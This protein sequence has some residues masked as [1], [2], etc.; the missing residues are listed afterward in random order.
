MFFSTFGLPKCILLDQ[1]SNFMSTMFSQVMR[2]LSVNHQISSAYHPE[3]QGVLERFLQTLKSMLRK[4]CVE[5]NREWDEG[6]PLLLFAFCEA[7][8]ESLGL[9][10]VELVFGHMVLG[11]LRLMRER[12]LAD[13]PRPSH[14]VLDYVSSFC[15]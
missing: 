1:G 5:L 10:L 12:W 6:L 11:P 3:S 7:T 4:Y 9:S 2:E 13:K 8:Q 14:S 15:G